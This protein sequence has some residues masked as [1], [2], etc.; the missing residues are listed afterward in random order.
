MQN[1]LK[2]LAVVALVVS[3]ASCSTDDKGAPVVVSRIVEREVPAEAKKPC[4]DPVR[5]PNRDLTE[6][7]ATNFWGQDRT[8][9][10]IC[11]TR[12]AAAVEGVK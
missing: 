9:L 11:E 6:R 3:V 12:R 10:R 7:E 5:L 2:S 8:A 1:W 4:A